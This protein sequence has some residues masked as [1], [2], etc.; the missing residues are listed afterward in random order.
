MI[1][2]NFFIFSASLSTPVQLFRKERTSY[3]QSYRWKCS[4][5]AAEKIHHHSHI[6]ES[7]LVCGC[8]IQLT[9]KKKKY[10]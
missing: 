1:Q 10:T 3:H 8:E 4:Y 6:R 9:K 5:P 2:E 7:A